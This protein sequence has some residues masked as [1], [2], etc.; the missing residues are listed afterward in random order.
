MSQ[1][2]IN[3]YLAELDFLKKAQ[4]T[5]RES[6]VREG[7]KERATGHRPA[8]AGDNRERAVGA[9]RRGDENGTP[10][11]AASVLA[12]REAMPTRP[13]VCLPA[14][15]HETRVSS[16][17]RARFRRYERR[18]SRTQRGVEF[19]PLHASRSPRRRRLRPPR[20]Q[21]RRGAGGLS[22]FA[23]REMHFTASSR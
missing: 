12:L 5:E 7:S 20:L 9:D 13:L 16:K 15:R 17:A 8:G 11:K 1:I 19:V 18:L 2:L 4:G 6:L 3:E 22:L 21:D 14:E 23:L 10:L